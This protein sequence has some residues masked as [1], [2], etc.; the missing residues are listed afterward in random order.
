MYSKNCL[1][2][3][4]P[5]SFFKCLLNINPS[6]LYPKNCLDGRNASFGSTKCFL[7]AI[8]LWGI[9]FKKLKN[10]LQ[11]ILKTYIIHTKMSNTVETTTKPKRA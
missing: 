2:T 7:K 3:K 4:R 5:V 11:I 1:K 6:G 8:P 10:T 9:D